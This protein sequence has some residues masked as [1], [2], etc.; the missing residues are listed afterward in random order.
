MA[1]KS[2]EAMRDRY[3]RGRIS[4]EKFLVYLLKDSPFDEGR[5]KIIQ[6]FRKKRSIRFLGK[7]RFHEK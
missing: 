6:E 3:L 5:R 4:G 1:R 7:L 2:L